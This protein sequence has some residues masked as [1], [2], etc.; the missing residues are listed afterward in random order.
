MTKLVAL[1]PLGLAVAGCALLGGGE[2]RSSSTVTA[3]PEIP[4]GY[5][6]TC[7]KS[8]EGTTADPFPDTE[9]CLAEAGRIADQWAAEHPG[10]TVLTILIGSHPWAIVC[11]KGHLEDPDAA[12]CGAYPQPD[13][14]QTVSSSPAT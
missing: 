10:S 13:P 2:I 12:Q 7:T 8:T 5:G 6:L 4:D 1:V 3:Y 14:G 9:A 11:A